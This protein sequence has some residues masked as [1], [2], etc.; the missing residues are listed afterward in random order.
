MIRVFCFEGDLNSVALH[1]YVTTLRT[2]SHNSI[3]ITVI[4]NINNELLNVTAVLHYR[5]KVSI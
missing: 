1:H 2:A 3:N 4:I 5:R